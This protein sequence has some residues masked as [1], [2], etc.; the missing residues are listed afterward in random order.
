MGT[1]KA[2]WNIGPLETIVEFYVMDITPHY[3]LLLGRAWLHPIGAITF[4][5]HQKMKIPWKWGIAIVLGDGEILASVYGL[6]EGGN[7]LQMSGFK[8]VN[9]TDYGL[10]DEKYTTDLLPYCSPEVISMMKKMGYMPSMGLG[11]EWRGVAEFPNFKTQLTKE[12]LRFFESCNGIKKNL[13]TL[14]GNFVKEGGD[15]PFYGFPKL[16]VDKDGKVNP[17]WEIFF[18][19]K[20]TFKEKPTVVTKEIQ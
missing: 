6:E 16:W 19:E 20:L 10:K 2:P 15:F 17:S 11:K 7:E 14:N 8:I 4:T 9:M 3:N 12:G 13:G 18:N 1:F 5:L